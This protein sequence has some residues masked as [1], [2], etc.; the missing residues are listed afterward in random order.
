MNKMK[1]LQTRLGKY[2]KEI[3]RI[4]QNCHA[5]RNR[6]IPASFA[7]PVIATLYMRNN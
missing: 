7:N 5:F 3:R 6:K 1:A 2:N 4:W